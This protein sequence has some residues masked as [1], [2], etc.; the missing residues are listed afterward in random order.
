MVC[1]PLK[2]LFFMF[3]FVCVFGVDFMG[4]VGAALCFGDNCYFLFCEAYASDAFFCGRVEFFGF[5]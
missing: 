2:S 4:L 3:S 1:L 5:C